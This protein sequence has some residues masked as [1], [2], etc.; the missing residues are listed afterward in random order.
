[1]YQVPNHKRLSFTSISR[2][3]LILTRFS[4]M[5]AVLALS[6]GCKEEADNTGSGSGSTSIENV[7]NGPRS[8]FSL[9]GRLELISGD[10]AF[11]IQTIGEPSASRSFI[12][13]NTG[14]APLTIS[15][16]LSSSLL[17]QIVSTDC[18]PEEVGG[19]NIVLA[20]DDTCEVSV[21]FLA[22]ALAEVQANLSVS[23]ADG[24]SL[25]HT[26]SG[27]G[28]ASSEAASANPANLSFSPASLNFGEAVVGQPI[29]RTITLSNSGS[30]PAFINDNRNTLLSSGHF[31]SITTN[32]AAASLGQG[33]SCQ[34]TLVF[35]PAKP[36]VLSNVSLQ[37]VFSG[38][39]LSAALSARAFERLV[40]GFGPGANP[41]FRAVKPH[42]P[43]LLN[44]ELEAFYPVNSNQGLYVASGDVNG[45]GIR[46]AIVAPRAGG[47]RAVVVYDGNSASRFD[48]TVIDNID[49][50]FAADVGVRV[51]SGDV[52]GDGRDEVIVAPGPGIPARVRIYTLVDL[53][54][55]RS[56]FQL[57]SV[58]ND[59]INGFFP[60][61]TDNQQGLYVGVGNFSG[62]GNM[63]VI[64]SGIS[65]APD[66]FGNPFIHVYSFSGT[67]WVLVRG[68]SPIG[69]GRGVLRVAGADI[70]GDGVDDIIAGSSRGVSGESVPSSLTVFTGAGSNPFLEL[71]SFRPYTESS[72]GVYVGALD[73]NGD[74]RRDIITGC[75]HDCNNT[76]NV[77]NPVGR[78]GIQFNPENLIIQSFDGVDADGD[79][80]PAA[81]RVGLSVGGF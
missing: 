57:L 50:P 68:F 52:N 28:R 67:N 60:F 31:S 54:S 56:A 32:C 24:S 27:S 53:P 18:L 25:T 49:S 2:N 21:S 47:G 76:V 80:G 58:E 41:L 11:G 17:F 22:N 9:G 29:T 36:R 69:K 48:P 42:A 78:S 12:Y 3:F 39:S 44:P 61:G 16:V 75:G 13:E 37:L 71:L 38:G 1:M 63:E 8:S 20:V 66:T 26:L 55:G 77:Y 35:A 79:A 51:T 34:Y 19:A 46:D 4:V 81:P 7:G 23:L 74:G 73:V 43:M 14:D 59:Q 10:L 5:V 64:A 30:A 6:T 72:D 45:D 70:N 65:D 15:S 33:Q 62:N 40:L